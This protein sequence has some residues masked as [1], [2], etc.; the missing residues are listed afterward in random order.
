MN[1]TLEIVRKRAWH[2]PSPDTAAAANM[3]LA[4]LQQFLLSGFTPSQ[5]QIA[6]LARRF[7]IE[8]RSA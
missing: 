4:Q 2:S 5:Q 6:A 8:E 7:D 1:S 3:S